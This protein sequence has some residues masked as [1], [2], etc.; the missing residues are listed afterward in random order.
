ML[1]FPDDTQVG[2]FGLDDVMAA[3]YSEGRKPT[4]ETAEEIIHRLEARKNYIP[5]SERARRDYAYVLLKEYRKFVK[6]RSCSGG[7]P[8]KMDAR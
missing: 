1:V 5:S 6:D 8:A 2:V 3:L 4:D 7:Q